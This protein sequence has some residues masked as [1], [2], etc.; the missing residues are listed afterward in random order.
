MAGSFTNTFEDE[1][2]NVV[3]GTTRT[4]WAGRFIGLFT[5]APTESAAG[6]EVA[7]EALA[8]DRGLGLLELLEDIDDLLHL[9][10]AAVGGLRRVAD[11]ADA[12]VAGA[13]VV[14]QRD[15]AVGA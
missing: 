14:V 8:L 13:G 7:G 11:L 4:G 15:L 9:H 5:V 2:L 10:R 1:I 6:T 12:G 3:R